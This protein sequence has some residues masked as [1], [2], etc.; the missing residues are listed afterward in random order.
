[1]KKLLPLFIILFLI[2]IYSCGGVNK[3]LKNKK[4][5]DPE[6]PYLTEPVKQEASSEKSIKEVEEKLVPVN[7]ESLDPHR[8]FVI[9]GSFRNPENAKQHQAQISKDKFTSVI[10]KNDA[11][12][13]RVSVMATD[14]V[15]KARDEVRR[16]RRT[17]PLYDDTWLLIQK[18]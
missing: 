7:N 9:I 10:L 2:G 11:G 4:Y 13:Y 1:M 15:E 14:D 17:F 18:K 6:N 8:F 16:I 3:S 12:L 5:T